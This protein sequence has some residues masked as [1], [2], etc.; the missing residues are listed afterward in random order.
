MLVMLKGKE[1]VLV[2]QRGDIDEG[3]KESGYRSRSIHQY[4]SYRRPAM[5]YYRKVYNHSVRIHID[6]D[7]F[8]WVIKRNSD[9]PSQGKEVFGAL[10]W[11]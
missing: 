7:Y 8:N 4:S 3:K 9:S 1:M 2:R 11:K 5:A 10:V 6:S